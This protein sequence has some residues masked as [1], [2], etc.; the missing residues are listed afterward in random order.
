MVNKYKLSRIQ[1]TLKN[2]FLLGNLFQGGIIFLITT[3][4]KRRGE[5]QIRN[6]SIVLFAM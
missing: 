6:L 2:G 3:R 5:E 1:L 4:I